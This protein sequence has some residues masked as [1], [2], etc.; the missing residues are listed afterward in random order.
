[1]SEVASCSPEDLLQHYRR[2]GSIVLRA[3]IGAEVLDRL[4]AEISAVFGRRARASGLALPDPVD[5]EGLSDLMVRMLQADRPAWM[6]A[7]KQTQYL[8]GVYRL[9]MGAEIGAVLEALGLTAPALSTR[10]VIHYMADALRIEGGYHKTPIH[11][12]WRGVQGSLDSVMIRL[13]LFDAGPEDYP[14]EI[15]PRSHRMGLLPT[16]EDAF[17][18]RVADGLV[19][20]AGFRGLAVKREDAVLLSNVLVHRAGEHGGERVRVA[21][22]FRDNN[23]AEPSSVV[24]NYPLPYVYHP[25]MKLLFPDLA[26]SA[27]LM[28]FTGDE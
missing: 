10:P 27:A 8:S 18:Q 15:L 7:A 1:M 3:L 23:A 21:L 13:P 6:A 14:L 28:P 22:S 2:E 9:A 25:S 24:R 19:D 17:G 26:T 16:V 20:E 11:Q 12:D 4:T 5:Q